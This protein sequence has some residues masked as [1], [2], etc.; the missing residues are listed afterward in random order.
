VDVEVLKFFLVVVMVVGLF[1]GVQIER[2]LF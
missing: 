1:S 2:E